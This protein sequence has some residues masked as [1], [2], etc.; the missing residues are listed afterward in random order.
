[1]MRRRIPRLEKHPTAALLISNGDATMLGSSQ[2]VL[3]HP[4]CKPRHV[5]RCGKQLETLKGP[6]S[7]QALSSRCKSAR[8]DAGD[9]ARRHLNLSTLLNGIELYRRYR[10]G[11]EANSEIGL[12]AKFAD[13]KK[14]DTNR[15][16]M[17]CKCAA[18]SR[19][20]LLGSE[21]R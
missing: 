20:P 9:G 4:S 16:C 1:M 15:M 2:V 12:T 18:D 3:I 19:C 21:P 5:L 13:G 14:A 10:S 17:C 6:T 7:A 8:K 11:I